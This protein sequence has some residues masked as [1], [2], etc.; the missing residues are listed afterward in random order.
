MNYKNNLKSFSKLLIVTLAITSLVGVT[1]PLGLV[2]VA[3]AGGNNHSQSSSAKKTNPSKGGKGNQK[4][5]KPKKPGNHNNNGD[6]GNEG[7]G[8]GGGGGDG[9]NNTGETPT[10]ATSTSVTLC[11]TDAGGNLLEGWELYLD[12]VGSEGGDPSVTSAVLN[13]FATPAFAAVTDTEDEIIH[14]YKGTTGEEGCFTLE[15]VEFGTYQIGEEER[16]GWINVS[17]LDVV[18]ITEEGDNSFT[19]KNQEI[20]EEPKVEEPVVGETEKPKEESSTEYIKKR[21]RSTIPQNNEVDLPEGQVLGESTE[22]PACGQYLQDY[23][24]LG[25]DN[26]EFEVSKLQIFLNTRGFAVEVSGIF[27]VE[28][29]QA[30][31]EFQMTYFDD[32]LTPWELEDSTGY[33]YKTT[34]WKINNLVCPGSEAFPSPLI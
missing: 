13:F 14:T 20:P 30:V 12:T 34:K 7:H 33:V 27:D 2:S 32:V 26:D 17:G 18:E 24:R 4:P 8:G 21:G 22:M 15:E 1:S 10:V 16:D 19:V 3:E 9:G 31:R 29:D 6:Y 5:N 25:Y 23:L 11:K 28:T